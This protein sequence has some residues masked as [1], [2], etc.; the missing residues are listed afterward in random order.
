MPRGS[1]NQPQE[2]A[3]QVPVDGPGMQPVSK[4]KACGMKGENSRN[5][6]LQTYLYQ[7]LCMAEHELVLKKGA[8]DIIGV[9]IRVLS[10]LPA[11][12]VFTMPFVNIEMYEVWPRMVPPFGLPIPE[13]AKQLSKEL[14]HILQSDQFQVLPFSCVHARTYPGQFNRNITF[15]FKHVSQLAVH[16]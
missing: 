7:C 1:C 12:E 10:E 11:N 8:L 15:V 5:A 14:N 9:F 13:L 4:F 3:E 6:E 2:E 16:T